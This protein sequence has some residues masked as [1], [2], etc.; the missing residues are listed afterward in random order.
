MTAA[1]RKDAIYDVRCQRYVCFGRHTW[2]PYMANLQN[3]WD[4]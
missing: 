4:D 3:L 1:H 2:R